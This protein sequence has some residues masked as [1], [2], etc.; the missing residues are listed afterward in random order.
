MLLTVE[1]PATARR[2]GG[3]ADRHPAAGDPRPVRGAGRAGHADGRLPRQWITAEAAQ[4]G[5]V[6]RKG[7]AAV[8]GTLGAGM[9]IPL[10]RDT[11]PLGEVAQVVQLPGR[12]VRRPV[13]T[14]PAG[15][16]RPGPRGRPGALGGS[17]PVEVV[18]APPAR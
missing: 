8:G 15:P 3:G 16:A 4:T 11:C 9:I 5:R 17:A 14:V 2:G 18:R 7:L 12:R 10:G 13:R 6:S 1:R